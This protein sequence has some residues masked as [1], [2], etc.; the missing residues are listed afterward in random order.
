MLDHYCLLHNFFYLPI[1]RTF[2]ENTI[3]A[4]CWSRRNWDTSPSR[5]SIVL[6]ETANRDWVSASSLRS[7]SDNAICSAIALRTIAISWTSC[8][9][10]SSCAFNVCNTCH[11]ITFKIFFSWLVKNVDIRVRVFRIDYLKRYKYTR[12]YTLC[13]TN[14]PQKIK[15]HVKFIYI[16]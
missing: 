6:H 10:R 2:V 13:L 16:F 8:P 15:K 4:S 9:I 11:H 3:W 1:F 7:C 14:I 12:T 5:S